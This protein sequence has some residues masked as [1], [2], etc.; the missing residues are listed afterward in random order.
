MADD[1]W[2]KCCL[3]FRGAA[4]HKRYFYGS[5][6]LLPLTSAFT[7]R[8]WIVL[9]CPL[10]FSFR[11]MFI[12][13][14]ILSHLRH[15]ELRISPSMLCFNFSWR[16]TS[17][18]ISSLQVLPLPNI[19]FFWVLFRTYS[20]WRALQVRDMFLGNA[21][22]KKKKKK[23]N[24]F[25]IFDC[26]YLYHRAIGYIRTRCIHTGHNFLNSTHLSPN[27]K[28]SWGPLWGSKKDIGISEEEKHYLSP[29][30]F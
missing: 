14:C 20:H 18:F 8:M 1:F 28:I 27:S 2:I 21:Q 25:Y 12:V 19:P 26:E 17:L 9:Q 7:V 5:V 23:L 30:L 6:S 13:K 11:F 16:I 29:E 22:K 15:L 24:F 4:S 3:I 10:S